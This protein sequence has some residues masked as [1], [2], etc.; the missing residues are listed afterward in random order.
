MLPL[1][2]NAEQAS[3]EGGFFSRT[4]QFAEPIT[5]ES[6]TGKEAKTLSATLTYLYH[7]RA[8]SGDLEAGIY[9]GNVVATSVVKREGLFDESRFTI[10]QKCASKSSDKGG[11]AVSLSLRL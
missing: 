6:K 11:I 8:L 7:R 3:T 4:W 1:Y 5:L 2:L 10:S 9:H